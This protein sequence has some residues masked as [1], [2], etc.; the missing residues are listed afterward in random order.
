M[1]VRDEDDVGFGKGGIVHRPV[2]QFWARIDF[3]FPSVVFNADAGV[4]QRVDLD[5]FP[6]F[7]G[8]D[9]GF[10]VCFLP[11]GRKKADGGQY[12]SDHI[13]HDDSVLLIFSGKDTFNSRNMCTLKHE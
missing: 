13:L 2:L 7:G 1:L 11:A 10:V 6:A 9:V 4:H 8:E 5:S 12:A 3:N